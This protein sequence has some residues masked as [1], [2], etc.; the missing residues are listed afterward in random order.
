MLGKLIRPILVT[1]FAISALTWRR[2]RNKLRK[3]LHLV[4]KDLNMSKTEEAKAIERALRS[5]ELCNRMVQRLPSKEN[6]DQEIKEVNN[7]TNC[8]E[9]YPEN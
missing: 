5:E 8:F 1:T 9:S 3:E 6:W 2:Q 4:K 7:T